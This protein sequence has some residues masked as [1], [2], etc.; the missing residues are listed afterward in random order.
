M[1]IRT[2]APRAAAVLAGTAASL[3]L[4]PAAFAADITSDTALA[5]GTVAGDG[6]EFVKPDVTGVFD[7][8]I[9]GHTLTLSA[10]VNAWTVL[11]KRGTGAGYDVSVAAGAVDRDGTTLASLPVTL[12]QPN[13]STA[14]NADGLDPA[15]DGPSLVT[16]TAV[17]LRSGAATIVSAD[18][19]QGMGEWT[20]PAT[21]E[22]LALTLPANA[23]A[24]AYS[25]TLTYTVSDRIVGP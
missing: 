22:T 4:V 15:T 19:D 20:V 18:A 16:T 13:G 6:L 8:T 3:A 1:S 14:T 9:T 2:H 7:G 5:T 17:N 10:P 24:G 11:D 12:D 21:A 25:T 23:K